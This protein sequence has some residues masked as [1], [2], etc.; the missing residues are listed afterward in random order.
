MIAVWDYIGTGPDTQE[1]K[2][3]TAV[4]NLLHSQAIP[5]SRRAERD[6]VEVISCSP[7]ARSRSMGRPL[8]DSLLKPE[9]AAS[10]VL[11]GKPQW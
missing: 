6:S 1:G 8:D 7:D 2:D 3:G 9:P 5:G 10:A 4:Q 11:S